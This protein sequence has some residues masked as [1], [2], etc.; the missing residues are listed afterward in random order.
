MEAVLSMG[1]DSP[2]VLAAHMDELLQ[3][4]SRTGMCV[5]F[6]PPSA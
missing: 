4:K 2:Q 6:I 3:G 5:L 1:G